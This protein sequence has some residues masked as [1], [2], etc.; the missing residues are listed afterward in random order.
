MNRAPE[1]PEQ[2]SLIFSSFEE[3]KEHGLGYGSGFRSKTSKRDRDVRYYCKV[4]SCSAKWRINEKN[5]TGSL[6][7]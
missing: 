1:E 3:A 2:I 4:M 5:F 7:H 6:M